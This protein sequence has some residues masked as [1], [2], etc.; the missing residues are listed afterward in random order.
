MARL[1]AKTDAN[2]TEIVTALRQAGAK[3]QS[4]AGV[5]DGCPDLLIAFHGW[6]VLEVKDGSKPPSKQALTEDEEH[7]HWV[8]GQQAN[9]S[10]V[11]SVDDALKAIGA[12]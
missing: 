11:R 2:H 5:G 10:I 9:V 4:L 1:R 8:F 3:V 6:H 7:W 12:V